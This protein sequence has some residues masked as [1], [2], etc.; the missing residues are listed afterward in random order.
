[1]L[2]E[3]TVLVLPLPREVVALLELLRLVRLS[4]LAVPVERELEEPVLRL[5]VAVPVERLEELLV[6][7]PVERLVRLSWLVLPVEREEEAED[8]VL[9]LE[10]AL[11]PVER[12]VRLSWLALPVEREAEAEDPVLRLEEALLPV[13][14][15]EEL[16]VL[17]E[18]C[19]VEE[20]PRL[21]RSVCA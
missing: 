1:M 17:P 21:V 6:L 20:E 9:R 7:L 3:R 8:P 15:L 12:L 2:E 5:V 13:E 19:C 14:R 18:R 4:W 16:L 11:L 10:E